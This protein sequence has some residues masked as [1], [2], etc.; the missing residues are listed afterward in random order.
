[1]SK[2]IKLIVAAVMVCFAIMLVNSGNV[3]SDDNCGLAP[4]ARTG[5]TTSFATGD[6]GD[7]QMGI[8]WPDPRFTDNDDGTVTDNLTGL[9]WTKN[10]NPTTQE[11]SWQDALDYVAAMNAGTYFGYTD[12]RMPNVRELQSL[13]NYDCVEVWEIPV[14]PNTKGDGCWSEGDPFENVQG[15]RYWTSTSA[16]SGYGI[17]DVFM[18]NGDQDLTG[19]QAHVWTVRGTPSP[20]DGWP[21]PT[22]GTNYTTDRFGIRHYKAYNTTKISINGSFD[23]PTLGLGHG[24][25]TQVVVTVVVKEALPNGDDLVLTEQFPVSVLESSSLIDIKK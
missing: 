2:S 19:G 18:G 13:V 6:D 1:M 22:P 25:S 3:L 9:M 15:W 24:D 10:A 20:C 4:V 11:I 14:V 16:A 8:P 12:W 17:W 23:L 5:Q 7:L 21:Q